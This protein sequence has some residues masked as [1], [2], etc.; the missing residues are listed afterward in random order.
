MPPGLIAR[1]KS[2]AARGTKAQA[3]RLLVVR[4][5]WKGEKRGLGKGEEVKVSSRDV[6]GV[7]VKHVEIDAIWVALEL[8]LELEMEIQVWPSLGMGV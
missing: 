2:T 8:E 4:F 1:P 3:R 5:C 6:V 7:M